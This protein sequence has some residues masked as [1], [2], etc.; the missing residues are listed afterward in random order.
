MIVTEAM[1]LVRAR[2]L[3]A[4]TLDHHRAIV[5]PVS[6]AWIRGEVE[7]RVR[8]ADLSEP[9]RNH[10]AVRPENGEPDPD[11]MINTNHLPKLEP[12]INA[13]VLVGAM[14]CGTRLYG[15]DLED[16]SR[17]PWHSEIDDDLIL[18]AM[19]FETLGLEDRLS[20]LLPGEGR[21]VDDAYLRELLGAGVVAGVHA[22]IGYLHAF[23]EALTAGKVDAPSIPAPY[24][25]AV[26]AILAARLRLTARAAGDAVFSVLSDAQRDEVRACG[27]DPGEPGAVFPERPFL[28]RDFARAKVAIELPG[29][30]R[31]TLY[32]PVAGQL[33]LA[34]DNVLHRGVPASQLVGRYGTAVHHF[35]T[36]LPIMYRYSPINR[37]SAL[38]PDGHSVELE[39]PF[40]VAT[41]HATG[42]EATRYL[43]K[44]RRKG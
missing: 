34:V 11:R 1:R 29:V 33:L 2:R 44:V 7:R 5:G 12:W 4:G 10:A 37:R 18:A 41:L 3:L 9:L 24:A 32:T 23:D 30:D 8:F 38:G 36:A 43:N 17:G 13:S 22:L 15:G 31:S 6:R 40:A 27:V 21:V 14:L 25:H 28:E 35:H 19:V 16:P 39:G 26:A 42:L 20:A